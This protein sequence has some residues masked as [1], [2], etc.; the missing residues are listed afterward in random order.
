MCPLMVFSA[1]MYKGGVDK[2]DKTLCI[3][4]Q[5]YVAHSISADMWLGF[6]SLS[7]LY[8]VLL[9]MLCTDVYR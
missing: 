4:V 6:V 5:S 2:V 9:T 3:Y 1:D 7:W 8:T